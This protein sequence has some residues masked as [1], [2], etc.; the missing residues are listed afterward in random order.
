MGLNQTQALT[1]TTKKHIEHRIHFASQ[2]RQRKKGMQ[3]PTP[4]PIYSRPDLNY[5]LK[6]NLYLYLL[7]QQ[8]LLIPVKKWGCQQNSMGVSHD[9][10]IFWIFFR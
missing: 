1:S 3:C 4:V 10:Y 2:S 5:V 9:F 6:W 7:I 8:K